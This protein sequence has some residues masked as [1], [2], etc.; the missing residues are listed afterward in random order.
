MVKH[1]GVG[2][3]QDQGI[4]SPFSRSRARDGRVC[5]A[6]V[7]SRS[8]SGPSGGPIVTTI[9]GAESDSGRCVMI[10]PPPGQDPLIGKT[11][12][13][14]RIQEQIGVSR[15]GKVYRAFQSSMNRSATVRVLS[16]EMAALPGK[17]EQ[18]L[19]EW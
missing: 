2:Q 5:R 8:T 17:A 3:F 18:F 12:R 7:L 6:H 19:E 1:P 10:E 11:L 4:H 16:P 9:A 14:Y 13:S 15:W